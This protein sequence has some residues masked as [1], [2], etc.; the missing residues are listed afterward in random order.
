MQ[1]AEK[2]VLSKSIFEYSDNNED[3]PHEEIYV[4]KTIDFTE[5]HSTVFARHSIA[6]GNDIRIGCRLKLNGQTFTS[7]L[8]RETKSADFF[9]TMHDG[10]IGIAE[11][12]FKLNGHCHVFLN[13]YEIDYVHHH[14]KEVKKSNFSRIYPCNNI[15]NKLLYLKVNSIEYVSLQLHVFH[16]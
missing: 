8:S 13:I 4:F 2:Y 9:L 16:N 15:Q 1:I 11:F 3:C 10:T 14:L 6:I 5:L 12:Y 7:L